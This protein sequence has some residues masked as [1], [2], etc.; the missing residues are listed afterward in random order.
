MPEWAEITTVIDPKIDQCQDEVY[1][2]VGRCNSI[3]E[4]M[5]KYDFDVGLVAVPHYLH[6]YLT[7]MLL[8]MG[9]HVIKEKPFASNIQEAQELFSLSKE[10]SKKIFITTQRSHNAIFDSIQVALAKPKF[11]TLTI[12]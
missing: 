8:R 10:G 1:S 2:A 7:S 4:A 12:G 11:R 5:P 6:Y 3:E 9:K